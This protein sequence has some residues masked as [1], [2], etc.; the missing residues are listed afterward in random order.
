MRF[1]LDELVRTAKTEQT[2]FHGGAALLMM[3]GAL[4]VAI[5]AASLQSGRRP[6]G[7]DH[8]PSPRRP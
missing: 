4:V 3:D 6:V 1:V 7:N 8:M 5:L 2:N